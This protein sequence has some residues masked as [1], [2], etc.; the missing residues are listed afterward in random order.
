MDETIEHVSKGFLGITMNC[1][2]CH[3]HKY[4]PIDQE[5]YYRMRAFFEPYHVR[6]DMVPKNSI[7]IAMGS[8][9]LSMAC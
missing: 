9:E 7:S 3:D 5:D 4:D 8:L 6:L 2:K 1:A